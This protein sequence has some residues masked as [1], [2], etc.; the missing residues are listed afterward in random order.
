MG[1]I[2]PVNQI[3]SP[4]KG[5][6]QITRDQF[7]FYEIRSTSKLMEEGLEDNEIV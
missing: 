4:Y 3:V 1:W 7:L 6:G 5:S 2:M